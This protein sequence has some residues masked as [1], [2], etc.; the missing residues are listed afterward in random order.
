MPK[1]KR[2]RKLTWTKKGEKVASFSFSKRTQ[3]V[4][5]WPIDSFGPRSIQL[6]VSEKK[7]HG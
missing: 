1:S 5:A 3:T 2:N 4:K 6:E 7:P